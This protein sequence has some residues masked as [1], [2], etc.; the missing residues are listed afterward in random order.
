MYKCILGSLESRMIMQPL[1][2]NK[3]SDY[4]SSDVYQTLFPLRVLAHNCP[5]LSIRDTKEQFILIHFFFL[6]SSPWLPTKII[7]SYTKYFF[8]PR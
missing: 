7:L 5:P 6:P 3:S 4:L 1:V 2:T 8:I